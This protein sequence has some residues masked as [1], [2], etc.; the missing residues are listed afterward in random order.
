MNIPLAL[1][2]NVDACHT[3]HTCATHG[4]R[5]VDHSGK[6]CERQ[7]LSRLKLHVPAPT[8]RLIYW[9][10]NPTDSLA[11]NT[12]WSGITPSHSIIEESLLGPGRP[13]FSPPPPPSSPLLH[14]TFDLSF[15]RFVRCNALREASAASFVTKELSDAVQQT[16]CSGFPSSRPEHTFS[17]QR[18]DTTNSMLQRLHA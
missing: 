12:E 11:P 15:N 6:A 8:I 1:Y 10:N 14:H 16:V 7:E 5:I 3:H 18:C 9:L 17:R 4:E 2:E 13:A